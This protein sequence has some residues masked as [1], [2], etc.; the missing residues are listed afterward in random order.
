M[1]RD[2]ASIAFE[3]IVHAT[4]SVGLDF[5]SLKPFNPAVRIEVDIGVNNN[6]TR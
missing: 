4:V 5:E 3:A 2:V 1:D 6:Q